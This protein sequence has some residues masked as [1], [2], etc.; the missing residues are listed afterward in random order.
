MS[1]IKGNVPA[2]TGSSVLTMGSSGLGAGVASLAV[3]AGVGS[4]GLTASV[5]LSDSGV[6]FFPFKR[7][8]NLLFSSESALGANDKDVSQYLKQ[9]RQNM[10]REG[11]ACRR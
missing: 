8:L 2:G 6:F 7:L 1:H 3:V 9:S 4:A 11:P 5:G 10:Y